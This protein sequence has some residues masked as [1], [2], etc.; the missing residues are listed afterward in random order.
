MS[1]C[2]WRSNILATGG[3][4][5]D[6]KIKLWNIYSGASLK[7][8]ETGSQI[9]SLL[10]SEEFKEIVSSHSGPLNELNIWKS[11][12]M[13]KVNSLIGHSSRVLSMVLSPDRETVLTAGADETL[14]L[15]KCF[16]LSERQK[17][18]KLS[19]ISDRIDSALCSSKFI[20]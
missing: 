19:K 4:R 1:W 13:S 8:V 18:Q 9:S 6:G 16:G 14:R 2:P 7:T 15:W 12:D 3:G 17:R 11:S 20:R 10:W 5:F